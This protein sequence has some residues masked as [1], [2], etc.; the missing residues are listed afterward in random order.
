MK[1]ALV[2]LKGWVFVHPNGEIETDYFQCSKWLSKGKRVTRN[3][4]RALHRPTC[5]MVLARMTV[6]SNGG[7]QGNER[8]SPQGQHAEAKK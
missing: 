7:R 5:R 6:V 1:Q 2:T 8:L 3:R 4:W